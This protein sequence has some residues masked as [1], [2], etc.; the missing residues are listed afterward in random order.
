MARK[1]ALLAKMLERTQGT[2]LPILLG[3]SEGMQR[4]FGIIRKVSASRCP[5]L[6]VG[7]TGTGKKLVASWIHGNGPWRNNPFIA[8]DCG[9]LDHDLIGIELFS[10]GSRR[11]GRPSGILA[12]VNGGTLLLDEVVEIPLDLQ[13]RL[14]RAIQEKEYRLMGSSKHVLF[15]ARIIATTSDDPVVTIREGRFR[16]DLYYRISAISIYLPPLRE[17]KEDLPLLADHILRQIT[18]AKGSGRKD[19]RKLSSDALALLLT[20]EWPGNVRELENCLEGA[21]ALSSGPVIQIEDLSL[22]L[23]TRVSAHVRTLKEIER[24]AI[25]TALRNAR[26]NKVA[27][28]RLLGIGKTTLYRKVRQYELGS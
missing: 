16:N 12:A 15:D 7:E 25:N 4:V 19:H 3:Q 14:A 5:V 23:G 1:V 17:R 20:H 24:E 27:A 9:S 28:A 10:T 26:G 11:T 8:V 18:R 2:R 21:V 6:M 22:M 13:R